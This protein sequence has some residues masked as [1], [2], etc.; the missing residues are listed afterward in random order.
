[1]AFKI[2]PT[3]KTFPSLN[4][5]WKRWKFSRKESQIRGIIIAPS[6]LKLEIVSLDRNVSLC[7]QVMMFNNSKS[8]WTGFLFQLIVH[9]VKG[10]FLDVGNP[11]AEM[12]AGAKIVESWQK[13]L[14]K[15][16]RD[17]RILLV[18]GL[19]EFLVGVWERFAY[20]ESL[21]DF[22]WYWCR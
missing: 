16:S 8:Q 19:G 9:V 17:R 13:K 22:F 2:I 15:L 7:T 18:Y 5:S 11:S 10:I 1:M 12:K 21:E 14:I 3:M 20:G 4:R 6:W